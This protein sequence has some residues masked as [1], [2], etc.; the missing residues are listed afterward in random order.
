MRCLN[1]EN[2]PSLVNVKFCTVSIHLNILFRLNLSNLI[3]RLAIQTVQSG[4]DV[5]EAVRIVTQFM[6]HINTS[7][8]LN[9]LRIALI[10]E[11][12]KN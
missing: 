5:A 10:A 11:G 4:I 6:G 12:K 1:S 9:K 7:V 2:L 8:L 3:F